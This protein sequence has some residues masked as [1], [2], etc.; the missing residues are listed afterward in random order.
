MLFSLRDWLSGSKL[1]LEDDLRTCVCT[2]YALYFFKKQE[3]AMH[4]ISKIEVLNDYNIKLWFSDGVTGVVDLS[5]LIGK[6]VFA[7]LKDYSRFKQA[8]IGEA[9]ELLW[10][11]GLDLCPD[12]LH[13]KVTGNW[14]HAQKQEPLDK[15]E[16]LI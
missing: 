12:S 10:P 7:S 5:N 3:L 2:G 14:Q 13:L 1:E 6:G 15:I 4:E 11:N 9:G 8:Q 16:P